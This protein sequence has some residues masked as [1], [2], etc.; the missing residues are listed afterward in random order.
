MNPHSKKENVWFQK[1][2]EELNAS[3]KSHLIL[4]SDF[5]SLTPGIKHKLNLKLELGRILRDKKYD[6]IDCGLPDQALGLFIREE[7][8]RKEALKPKV[9]PSGKPNYS[10]MFN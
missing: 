5:E 10:D 1:I 8:A 7:K 2:P 4:H 3:D 9:K 6:K